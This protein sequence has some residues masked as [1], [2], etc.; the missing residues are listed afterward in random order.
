VL[1]VTG[2]VQTT[3]GYQL[4]GDLAMDKSGTILRLA[5]Q[6]A[7]TQ[8]DLMSGGTVRWTINP[9]GHFVP[10]GAF[11]VG[12]TGNK[13]RNIF[14]SGDVSA[15]T[16]S[17]G[18]DTV[19]SQA[20]AVFHLAN[21][22]TWTSLVAFVAGIAKLTMLA[23]AATFS[24]PVIS[25]GSN[26]K[27]ADQATFANAQTD[28][29]GGSFAVGANETWVVDAL[30][31]VTMVGTG[32]VKFYFTGPAGTTG[33]VTMVGTGALLTTVESVYTAAITVPGVFLCRVVGTC[34]VLVRANIRIA[35]TA[36]TV[37]LVGITSAAGVTCLVRKGFN[38]LAERIT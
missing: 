19:L 32:G 27:A 21:D 8:I 36:G 28:I 29:A 3:T 7:I 20:G 4:S 31:E 15:A 13:I 9:S 10:N 38:F 30:L 16:F 14:A 6:A 11:D 37:Q 26:M 5:P 25:P 22:A 35:G 24:V 2:S 12:L 18:V 17:L 23:T 34:W 1:S 33:E